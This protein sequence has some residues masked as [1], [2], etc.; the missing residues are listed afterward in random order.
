MH[1]NLWNVFTV[2]PHFFL[3]ILDWPR[4]YFRVNSILFI[5]HSPWFRVDLIFCLRKRNKPVKM[6][7]SRFTGSKSRTSA[8]PSRRAQ[9]APAPRQSYHSAPQAKPPATV[10]KAAPP[11]PAPAPAAQKSPGM[12]AQMAAN[13]GSTAAGVAIGMWKN[14]KRN[15][16]FIFLLTLCVGHGISRALFG[17]SSSHHETA[18]EQQQFQQQEE[19]DPCTVFSNE[20]LSC[21]QMNQNAPAN[22]QPFLTALQSCRT[23]GQRSQQTQLFD[24]EDSGMTSDPPMKM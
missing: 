4:S 6:A 1:S 5:N 23:R 8:P 12:L 2:Q 24:D 3:V 21:M 13:A 19:G 15:Y 20:F 17:G 14:N 16:N 11:A 10:P 22:C 18:Q 9:Q 7:R